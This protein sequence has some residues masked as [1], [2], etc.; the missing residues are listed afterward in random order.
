[1]GTEPRPATMPLFV[2]R[3]GPPSLLPQGGPLCTPV[4]RQAFTC[5]RATLSW[6]SS[7]R[8]TIGLN[9]GIESVR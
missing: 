9:R 4:S 6:S 7:V 5:L 8:L 2:Q 3:G 1:M